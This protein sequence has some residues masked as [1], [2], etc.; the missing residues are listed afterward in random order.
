METFLGDLIYPTV[1]KTK[2]IPTGGCPTNSLQVGPTTTKVSKIITTT[3]VSKIITTPKSSYRSTAHRNISTKED[4]LIN[5]PTSAGPDF[6][7]R[8]NLN[9]VSLTSSFYTTTASANIPIETISNGVTIDLT[10]LKAKAS[11]IIPTKNIVENPFD[12]KSPYRIPAILGMTLTLLVALSALLF[13]L[14]KTIFVKRI[15]SKPSSVNSSPPS[16]NS[17]RDSAEVSRNST[18]VETPDDIVFPKNPL[19]TI[20][21]PSVDIDLKDNNLIFYET[22]PNISPT[23]PQKVENLC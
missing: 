17:D 7:T 16:I 20:S 9:R 22:N 2:L 21:I 11:S 4:D 19:S 3:K 13:L 1:V 15:C 10:V 23:S 12:S 14:R 6:Q 18:L 5:N 8:K